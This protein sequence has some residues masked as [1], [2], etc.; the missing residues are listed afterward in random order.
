[1]WFDGVGWRLVWCVLVWCG[2]CVAVTDTATCPRPR[3]NK[4]WS[5]QLVVWCV[6]L[7]CGLLW[8]DVLCCVVLWCFVVRHSVPKALLPNGNAQDGLHKGNAKQEGCVSKHG[9]C[10]VCGA[11]VAQGRS[12]SPVLGGFCPRRLLP[13]AAL[14]LYWCN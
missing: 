1:M 11:A 8:C 2:V 9:L 6:V 10:V 5:A 7:H 4:N 13:K 12:L 14:P 3:Q